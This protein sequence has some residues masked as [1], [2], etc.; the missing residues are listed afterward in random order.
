MT[1]DEFAALQVGDIVRSP[2]GGVGRI[3]KI[4]EG[5]PVIA[6]DIQ[7]GDPGWKS[8]WA[9]KNAN[10]LLDDCTAERPTTNHAEKG[11]AA[12]EAFVKECEVIYMALKFWRTDPAVE[13]FI[14][15]KAETEDKRQRVS[16]IAWERDE[17]GWKSLWMER[18]RKA[19]TGN[20]GKI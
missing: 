8:K 9:I 7:L 11:K 5:K 4:G 3:T 15:S 14:G 20:K 19:L 17:G 18:T 10:I 13:A 12:T 2:R 16:D 1:K 6:I